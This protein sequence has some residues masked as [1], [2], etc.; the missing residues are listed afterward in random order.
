MVSNST[1]S[2]NDWKN[3]RA[4]T[5]VALVF[6]VKKIPIE[7]SRLLTINR[8]LNIQSLQRPME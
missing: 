2:H 7:Q 4:A 8:N 5:W 3:G 6:D 1:H